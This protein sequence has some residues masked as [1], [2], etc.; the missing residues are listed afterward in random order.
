MRRRPLPDLR[1]FDSLALPRPEP[2][3]GLLLDF[4]LALEFDSEGADLEERA[5]VEVRFEASAFVGLAAIA[6]KAGRE[7]RLRSLGEFDASR[8]S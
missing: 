6:P 1:G 4:D 7:S 5:W 3:A 8:P 2:N